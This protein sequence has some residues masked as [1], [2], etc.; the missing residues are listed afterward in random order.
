NGSIDGGSFSE[1]STGRVFLA[2]RRYMD[3]APEDGFDIAVLLPQGLHAVH[4][5]PDAGKALEVGLDVGPRLSLRDAQVLG[6]AVRRDPI[7]DA[8]VDGLGAAPGCRI[9]VLQGHAKDLAGG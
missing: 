5:I 7:D 9:H 1:S 6:Q 3:L 2:Q 4:V 8:E